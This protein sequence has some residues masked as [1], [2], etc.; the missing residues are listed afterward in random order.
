MGYDATSSSVTVRFDA[1]LAGP[2]DVLRVR[3]FE[4]SVSGVAAETEA[5]APALN[6][7]ANDVAA[8]VANWVS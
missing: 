1:Q 2:G 7:A 6:R 5:V 4:A 3:R 8:Q